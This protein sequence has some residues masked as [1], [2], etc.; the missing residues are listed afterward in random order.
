MTPSRTK[1]FSCPDCSLRVSGSEKACPRCGKDFGPDVKLECPF[2]GTLV[3]PHT[4]SCS[5][6]Q[7]NYN[8][9]VERAEQR[10][11]EKAIDRI[12]QEIDVL[13]VDTD[14]KSDDGTDEEEGIHPRA[15]AHEDAEDA[16]CPVCDGL[17]STLDE[18]CPHCGAVFEMEARM[19]TPSTHRRPS[20]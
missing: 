15:S 5:A 1:I 8:D 17:V 2:C 18:E 20:L 13:K 16:M 6:C 19:R 12:T 4:D 14:G 7:I 11:L 9:F 10:I 3:S